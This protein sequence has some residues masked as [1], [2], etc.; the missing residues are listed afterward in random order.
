[1]FEHDL[2]V[3]TNYGAVRESRPYPTGIDM[4]AVRNMLN[5]SKLRISK[6][7]M[8]KDDFDDI[9]KWGASEP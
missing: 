9:M 6:I 7:L 3:V 1:M 8:S 2:V 5:N 4:R